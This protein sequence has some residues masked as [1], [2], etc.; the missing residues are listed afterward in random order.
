MGI[1]QVGNLPYDS[2]RRLLMKMVEM[3]WQPTERQLRQF[4]VVGLIALPLLA[5]LWDL[6]D[7]AGLIMTTIGAVMGLFAFA[8]P[9]VLRYPFIALTL[10]TLPIGMVVGEIVLLVGYYGIF[11]PVG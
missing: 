10:M 1:G 7:P 5:W 6:N 11:L 8:A 2:N 3:N 4:G 9:D